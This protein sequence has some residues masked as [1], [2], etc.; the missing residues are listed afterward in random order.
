[1]VVMGR[2]G[3]DHCGLPEFFGAVRPQAVVAT[4]TLFPDGE[5]IPE[6]FRHRLARSGVAL[7]DQG[8]SGAVEMWREDGKLVLKG[9]VDG[10]I[11]R[12]SPGR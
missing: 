8:R 4:S 5:A 1:V 10:R 9:F 7:F 2:H 6:T 11:V 3:S 12:L